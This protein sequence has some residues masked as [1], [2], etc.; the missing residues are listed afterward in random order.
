MRQDQ[1][2]PT[3]RVQD[4]EEERFIQNMVSHKYIISNHLLPS[5]KVF[6]P[7]RP[8]KF[9]PMHI[10]KHAAYPSPAHFPVTG[11]IQKATT[12]SDH[13]VPFS[14]EVTQKLAAAAAML[15]LMGLR[16]KENGDSD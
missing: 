9:N 10:K 12:S 11:I 4:G 3:T 1:L 2:S 15:L 14:Q 13:K 5:P 6:F 16:M 8:C 7:Q